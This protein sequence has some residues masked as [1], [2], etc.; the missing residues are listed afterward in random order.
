MRKVLACPSRYIQGKGEMASIAEHSVSLGSNAFILISE[1]GIKRYGENIE[2]GFT[3]RNFPF[4]FV[5]FEG[6]CSK[7]EIERL[8]KE[9][10]TLR[11]DFIVGVGGGKIIDTAKAV[12]YY[13]SVPVVIAPTIASTDAP[14]S[15]LSVLYT[16]DGQFDEYLFLPKNP[17]VVLVDTAVVAASP[18]RFT[19]SGMG[20]A[21]AT[22][23]E[24]TSAIGKDSDNFVGGKATVAAYAIAE[25]CYDILLSHGKSAVEALNVGAITQ[26]VEKIIEANTL[27]SGV[28]FESCGISAAHSV[29]NGL[30][31]LHE[32]HDYYHGEKVAFGVLTQLIL[33]DYPIEEIEEVYDFCLSVG[34][35]V[36][37][38][39]LGVE[40]L[41]RDNLIKVAQLAC[42]PGETIHNT[43]VAVCPDSVLDAML[44]ADA[45]GKMYKA[46]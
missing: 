36:T 38:G 22:Y 19:V 37:L 24:A 31:A 26:A 10:T 1:N 44:A 5:K 17:D 29:H 7:E 14:C 20:D 42:A 18:P 35:P 3:E 46:Q 23:F 45:L 11:C 43:S 40:D 25:L 28:G 2:K 15:A 32:T 34:L 30:T 4:T 8:R 39:E 27:L 41:S 9:Y 12:A 16:P 21:L 6:E 13:E 33:E